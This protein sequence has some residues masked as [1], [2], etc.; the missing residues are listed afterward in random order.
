MRDASSPRADAKLDVRQDPARLTSLPRRGRAGHGL[1]GGQ[2]DTA[3]VSGP[4]RRAQP[5]TE[6]AA[7]ETIR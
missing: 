1:P 6:Y 4:S 3:V 5:P 7:P 2:R